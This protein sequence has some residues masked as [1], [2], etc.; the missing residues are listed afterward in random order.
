MI[1]VGVTEIARLAN[2]KPDTVKKWR[3]RG[4]FPPPAHTLAM[5]PVWWRQDVEA[6][7]EGRGK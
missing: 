4:I 5:G 3:H 1:P 6:W 7:I 2:V